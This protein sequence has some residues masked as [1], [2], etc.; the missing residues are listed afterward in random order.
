MSKEPHL[1]PGDTVYLHQDVGDTG[2]LVS[3]KTL[4]LLYIEYKK[5]QH[6]SDANLDKAIDEFFRDNTVTLGG[7]EADMIVPKGNGGVAPVPHC[8]SHQTVTVD[9]A[10]ENAV[11][12]LVPVLAQMGFCVRV[13]ERLDGYGRSNIEACPA[14]RHWPSEESG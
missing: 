14:G 12:I 13:T 3:H 11:M 2:R 4:L 1:F 10:T 5:W 9:D 7:D 8:G 6:S